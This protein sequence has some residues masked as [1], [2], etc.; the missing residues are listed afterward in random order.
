MRELQSAFYLNK[1]FCGDDAYAFPACGIFDP[2]KIIGQR[3][4]KPAVD[5]ADRLG[6][7]NLAGFETA[8]VNP[9]LNLNMCFGFDLQVAFFPVLAVIVL[10]RAFDIN[11]VRIVPLDEIRVITIHGTD[12]VRERG[13]KGRGQAT[14]ETCGFGRKLK[15]EIVKTLAGLG[16]VAQQQRLHQ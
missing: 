9:A 1:R 12:K 16:A 3:L 5:F 13:E 2:E 14:A 8:L 15:C 7:D 4:A 11:R 6:R 10:Q